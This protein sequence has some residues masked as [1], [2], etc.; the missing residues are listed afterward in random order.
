MST[1]IQCPRIKPTCHPITGIPNEKN[2]IQIHSNLS[3][4]FSL[5]QNFWN[6]DAMCLK[7]TRVPCTFFLHEENNKIQKTELEVQIKSILVRAPVLTLCWQSHNSLKPY[8]D[9][10][11]LLSP[12]LVLQF[13]LRIL[14]LI[15]LIFGPVSRHKKWWLIRASSQAPELRRWYRSEKFRDL[16]LK[17]VLPFLSALTMGCFC[18][19]A[20]QKNSIASFQLRDL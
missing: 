12:A 17:Q 5:Y 15:V 10:N 18:S 3:R 14:G 16:Q 7:R 19:A 13:C 1:S 8:I 20:R 6:I 9:G 4:S 2:W 11:F